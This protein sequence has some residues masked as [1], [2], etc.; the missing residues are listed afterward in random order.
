[1]R[2]RSLVVARRSD[3]W[4][5]GV[6][7]RAGLLCCG[8]WALGTWAWSL[9]RSGGVAL[10]HVGPSQTRDQTLTPALAAGSLT[11]R[12]P[13]KAWECGVLTPGPGKSWTW[14]LQSKGFWFWRGPVYHFISCGLC[15][16]CHG[17]F[18]FFYQSQVMKISFYVSF[19]K[20]IVFT[21]RH[22]NHLVLIFVSDIRLA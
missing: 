9:W 19:C 8:A 4:R 11:T 1:M 16:W 14:L 2:E 20:F 22:T 10:W 5:A 15:L 12:P 6:S 7:S 3:W 13:G 17:F 21:F 18:F